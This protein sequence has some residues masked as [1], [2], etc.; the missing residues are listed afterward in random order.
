MKFIRVNLTR[1]VVGLDFAKVSYF[2][3]FALFLFG[4]QLSCVNLVFKS[5]CAFSMPW[6]II[7][8]SIVLGYGLFTSWDSFQSSCYFPF[9]KDQAVN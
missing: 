8:Y 2:S 9:R 1:D 3:L 6:G 5:L 4:C 7:E